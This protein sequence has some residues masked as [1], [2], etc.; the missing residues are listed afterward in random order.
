[1]N[2]LLRFGE[3]GALDVDAG[4]PERGRQLHRL[5]MC[6]PEDV[7]LLDEEEPLLDN[8][9]LLQDGDNGDAVLLPDSGSAIDLALNRY[10]PDLDVLAA[11]LVAND[12]LLLLRDGTYGDML[13]V[14]RTFKNVRLLL[15]DW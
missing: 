12:D 14:G 10:P 5:R 13:D 2:I 3:I 6:R 7:D 8:Q 15:N 1:M 4:A 11:D 9:S